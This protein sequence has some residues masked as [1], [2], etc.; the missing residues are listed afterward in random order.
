MLYEVITRVLRDLLRRR[1]PHVLGIYLAGGWG[2]LEFS[3]FAVLHFG[4]AA[5]WTTRIMVLLAAGLRITSYNV[6]YTK[7]LRAVQHGG[8]PTLRNHPRTVALSD[9]EATRPPRP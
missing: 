4:L 2:L 9:H 6:C 5:A 1:V 3:D 8:V 7:L